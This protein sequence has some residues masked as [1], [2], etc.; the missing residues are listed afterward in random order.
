MRLACFVL[1]SLCAAAPAARADQLILKN[2]DRITG[3][4]VKK[5]GAKVTLK[6]D[7]MGDVTVAW[8]AVTSLSS[9]E[10]V[11][12]VLP[13]G[14]KVLGKLQTTGDQVSVV[15]S[16]ATETA[17]LAQITAIRN[18]EE[19]RAYDRLER[20]GFA[21]LWAGYA[22]LGLSAARGNAKTNT[23][24]TAVNAVRATRTDKT[25]VY[26]NQIY[27]T[28]TINGVNAG[29]A[30]ALRGGIAYNRNLRPRLFVNTFN[31][32]EY[33]R[34]QNL[35]LRFVL[36]GGLGYSTIKNERSQLDLLGGL[37]YKHET[38]NTPLTRKSAEAYGGDDFSHKLSART[39]L[40]QSFRVFTNVTGPGE[41]RMNFDLGA[42]TNLWKWL[43]FQISASDRF[44]SNP[45]GGRQRND[46]LLTTGLRLSFAR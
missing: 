37:D 27:A 11:T 44:L 6:S 40:R 26:F 4:L 22:D 10:P 3:K 28:A 25:T 8:D 15:T 41:R 1:L 42:N 38:F 29:T 24:T 17:A 5:D 18:T 46:V 39:S 14:R 43:A 9:D 32:Y 30:N 20:P 33:D 21:D 45:V 7:L 12:V 13:G 35:D 23:F 36:G 16:G 34:F 31:D 2:G 19:Q